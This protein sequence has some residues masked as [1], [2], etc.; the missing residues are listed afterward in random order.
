[1]PNK[2]RGEIEAEI[3][4]G[5][6]ARWDRILTPVHRSETEGAVQ[7]RQALAAPGVR[8]CPQSSTSYDRPGAPGPGPGA[9]RSAAICSPVAVTQAYAA[10]S[11]VARDPPGWDALTGFVTRKS[12]RE[13]GFMP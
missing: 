4:H 3:G 7:S 11:H 9:R 1:M 5:G 8:L 2:H 12:L 6:A 10:R 13:N